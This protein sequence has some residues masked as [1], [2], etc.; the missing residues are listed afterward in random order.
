MLAVY[1]S[2]HGFGHATRTA[3]V[4]RA[5]R[6]LEPDLPI[7]VT[8]AA[9]FD[10]FEG[11]VAPPLRLRQLECDIGLAQKDALAIDEA[12]TAER[13]K[14]HARRLPKL[15]ESEAALLKHGRARVVLG[16]VPPLAF[17]AAALADVPSVAM[18]NFS[19]DW[20]YRH[21]TGRHPALGEAADVCARAYARCGLLLRLPF[22]GDMSA[23]PKIE[24]IPLV[25]RHP[26]VSR[27]DARRRLGLPGGPLVLLSFGGLGVPGFQPAVL[28]GL[29]GLSF[30]S[31]GESASTSAP[32]ALPDN[33][34]FFPR[35]RLREADLR[36]EDLVGAADVVVTK[37]GYGIVSDAIGAGTAIVYTERG[38]FPEYEILVLGM[39]RHLPCAHVSNEDLR[40]GRLREPIE[41]VLRA[42]VPE[43]PRLDGAEV[44][45]ERILLKG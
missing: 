33:V 23:F 20:I 22:A 31:V 7:V 15:V 9:P 16:D 29:S 30:F 13:W 2:G 44:A 28:G 35:E 24:D 12:A 41:A 39:E 8:T 26:H 10:L 6:R 3:E 21:Y 42:P 40:A 38:D 27:L 1:V 17:A 45:A 14:A 4:L 18:A 25:A 11:V 36:Y 34:T 19:W 37:P 43:P 32:S 5:V